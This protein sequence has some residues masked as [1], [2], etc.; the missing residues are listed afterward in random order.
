MARLRDWLLTRPKNT[1]NTIPAALFCV[2]LLI[3]LYTALAWG[4]VWFMTRP[5]MLNPQLMPFGWRIARDA[6]G[7]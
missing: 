1:P 5:W 4:L 2:G 7:F 3:V 6:F